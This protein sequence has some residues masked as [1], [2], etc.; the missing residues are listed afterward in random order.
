MRSQAEVQAVASR[1]GDRGRVGEQRA[2]CLGNPYAAG[3]RITDLDASGDAGCRVLA[4][5]R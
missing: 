1:P 2:T 5:C 3:L 4:G